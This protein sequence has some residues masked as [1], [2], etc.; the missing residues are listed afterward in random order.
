MKLLHTLHPPLAGL[1]ALLVAALLSACAQAPAS[2]EPRAPATVTKL[3]WSAYIKENDHD[4]TC[5][6]NEV[7]IG[8]HHWDAEDKPTR[9]RC[10]TVF[11]FKDITISDVHKSDNI[12]ES[13]GKRFVCPPNEIMV[14]RGHDDDEHGPTWYYCGKPG[15]D[16]WGNPL[17]VVPW[18]TWIRVD[19]EEK[20]G[21]VEC[22]TDSVMVGRWHIDDETGPTEYLCA[23][24]Y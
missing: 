8:R 10:A 5:G 16:Y 4:F 13:S 9:Y 19:D 14:G 24:V 15:N 17:S 23:R 1:S 21:E 6:T 22:P 3:N 2:R 11:Q 18:T 7:M 12:K 20:H